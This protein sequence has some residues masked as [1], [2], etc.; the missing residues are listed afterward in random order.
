MA[1]NYP[2]SLDNFSNPSGTTQ[3]SDVSYLHNVQHNDLND[4]VE[5]LE[6]KLG[7]GTG[8]PYSTSVTVGTADSDYICDGT[9]DHIQIQEA[10]DA[11]SAAGGGEVYIK[12]ANYYLGIISTTATN[13]ASTSAYYSINLKS[14]VHLVG[15]GMG[16]TI[17]N[18]PAIPESASG[19]YNTMIVNLLAVENVSIE[20][21]SMINPAFTLGPSGEPYRINGGFLFRG[22]KHAYFRNIRGQYGVSIAPFSLVSSWDNATKILTTDTYDILYENCY[23]ED[24]VGSATLTSVNDITIRNCTMVDWLDD[25]IIII[26]AGQ[27]ITID[28][29]TYDGEL[30]NTHNGAS[31]AVIYAINDGSVSSDINAIRDLKIMNCNLRR[32]YLPAGS[33]AGI[34]LAAVKDVKI[35]NNVIDQ[36]GY[37]VDNGGGTRWDGVEIAGNTIKNNRGHGIFIGNS[38][39]VQMRNVNIHDNDIYNNTG[40]GIN[41]QITRV[42]TYVDGVNIHDNHVFDDQGVATQTH[43]IVLGLSGA[44]VIGDNVQVHDNILH[45]NST[46]NMY[47][48]ASGGA[49]LTARVHHNTGWVTEAQGTATILNGATSVVVT[50]GLGSTVT[51]ITPTIQDITVTLAELSTADPGEIYVDTITSTQFTIRCRTDPGISGLDLAW[52]AI[53][54]KTSW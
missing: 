53:I 45:G 20:N 18:G 8:T 15:E 50:H 27:R 16:A 39:G 9:N 19:G 21:M 23:F 6:T 38:S 44:G 12:A 10:I 40:M 49:A 1:I 34:A 29:F 47:V 51:P 22:V 7:T 42:G 14:N 33:C 48:G 4:A 32:F 35:I 11:V 30:D 46:Y 13:H 17:L 26:G 36:C 24:G 54:T 52:K 2:T 25:P 37:G 43:G 3:L 31:T 5:A 41:C 28:N